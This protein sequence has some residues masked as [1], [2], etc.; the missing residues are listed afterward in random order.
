M[1]PGLP[2][3]ILKIYETLPRTVKGKGLKMKNNTNAARFNKN[4]SIEYKWLFKLLHP[5]DY[6][7]SNIHKWFI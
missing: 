2:N 6:L 7:D 5:M 3:N 4:K 1:E